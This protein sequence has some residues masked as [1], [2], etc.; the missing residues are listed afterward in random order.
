MSSWKGV[1]ISL[2]FPLVSRQFP[3]LSSF[4]YFP[5]L[6][7]LFFSLLCVYP[8]LLSPL[9]PELSRKQGANSFRQTVW[10]INTDVLK[11]NCVRA[12]A[13]T[14]KRSQSAITVAQQY[15]W[16]K[17][18]EDAWNYLREKNTEV[19]RL[20]GKTLSEVIEHFVIG[21]DETCM[22]A[23][24]GKLMI[25]GT[26]ERKKH[27]KNMLDSRVTI[28]MYR[29]GTTGG[30]T[31]STAFLMAGV[32]R[33]IGYDEAFLEK[34]GAATGSTIAMTP[35]GFMTQDAW[36]EI[37]PKMVEGIRSLPYI[38]ENP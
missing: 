9:C 18:Y 26:K 12:Q 7:S 2:S 20:T 1:P 35:T 11:P 27:E 13:T 34:W 22:M 30:S 29:T 23:C 10:K 21:G 15:R 3:S 14:R 4:L 24:G 17:T 19:C 16:F 37:T 28:T 6:S 36:E 31:G 38:K 33:R 5:S 32:K 8:S 25:V